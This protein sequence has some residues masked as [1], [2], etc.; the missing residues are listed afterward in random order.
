MLYY[1]LVNIRLLATSCLLCN[2]I[3]GL[4]S[5]APICVQQLKVQSLYSHP[6]KYLAKISITFN[7]INAKGLNSPYKQNLLYKEALAQTSAILCIHKTNFISSKPPSCTHKQYP[8]CY[9]AN[10]TK[11]NAGV[12][13]SIRSS[14]SLQPFHTEIDHKGRFI[15]LNAAMNNHTIIIANIYSP[16]TNQHRFY[17]TMMKKLEPFKRCPLVICGDFNQIVDPLLDNSNLV[18]KCST[19]LSSL[20]DSEDLYDPWRALHDTKW[21]TLSFQTQKN[22][23][24]RIDLLL[25]DKHTL[26]LGKKLKLDLLRG[27]TTHRSR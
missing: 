1:W 2:T 12:I 6:S 4:T 13:F 22:A 17:K 21:T 16:N 23:Y 14:V 19:S 25:T 9:F 15:I 27:L 26:Q 8:H 24:S 11:K 18:R 7:S 5:L 10:S 20:I 3:T